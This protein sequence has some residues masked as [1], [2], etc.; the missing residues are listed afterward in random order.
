[1]CDHEQVHRACLAIAVLTATA[2]ALG[3]GARV[4]MGGV[5]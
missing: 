4:V 3:A 2:P 1:V 5:W